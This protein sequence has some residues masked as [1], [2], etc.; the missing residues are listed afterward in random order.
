MT[1]KTP[2]VYLT[3]RERFSAAHRLWSDSLTDEQ[4]HALYGP[5][6]REYGHGHNYVIEVTLRGDV[7]PDTGVIVNLTQ[8]RDA[9]KELIIEDT[10]HRHL[11][12]NSELCKGIN[13]TAENLVVLFWQV[14][15]K[16]FGKLMHEVRLRETDKNWVSYRGE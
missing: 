2:T 6:A 7:D 8:V 12:H 9:I 13:P 15:H 4:N 16:R 1:R 5:C 11:N 14:L 10:D 3:R